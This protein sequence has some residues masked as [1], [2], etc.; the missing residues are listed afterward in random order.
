MQAT[1]D[2]LAWDEYKSSE[3][4]AHFCHING[5]EII[6]KMY[7]E[8]ECVLLSVFEEALKNAPALILID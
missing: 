8:S 6:G 2:L 7:V 5:A 3:V 1:L 4:G